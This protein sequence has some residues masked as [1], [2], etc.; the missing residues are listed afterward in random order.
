M[1]APL[2]GIRILDLSRLAPGPYCSMLLADLGADV[3]KVEEPST[4]DY[5]RSMF[6]PIKEQSAFFISLNRNKRSL[7]VNLKS[8]DGREIIKKLARSSDVLLEGFRPGVMDRLGLGYENIKKIN[9]RLVYCSLSGY[10]QD[11]PYRSQSGHDL[12]YI[13]MGGLLGLTGVEGGPP[14]VP[15]IPLSDLI[16]GLM[17]ALGIMAALN[18]RNKTGVGQSVDVA[19]MDAV[20]S[21]MGMSVTQSFAKGK[22]PERGKEILTGMLP[23]YNVYQTKDGRY[24]ALGALE[25]KFWKEFC[26]AVGREELG[27]ARTETESER[28]KVIADIQKI[29]MEKDQEQWI[30]L[31]KKKDV[32]C[33]AV[34]D[35][36]QVSR[37]P[38]VLARKMVIDAFHPKEGQ[39]KEVGIPIKFSETPGEIKRES[40]DVGEHTEE[41]L[42]EMGFDSEQIRAW[43]EVGIV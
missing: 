27:E 38:Q 7:T 12:N 19:M 6:P 4:G 30:E 26:K 2:D 9:P 22:F 21:L 15:G 14:V 5:M 28:K 42:S 10:G 16:G 11:G 29:F 17:A 35:L 1:P 31:F 43:R 41:I 24:M 20:I 33:V 3:I 23:R 36:G 39:L 18:A 40:P 25:D 37:D 34:Y 8:E 32:C 13:A